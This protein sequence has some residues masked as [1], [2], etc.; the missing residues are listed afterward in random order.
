[1]QIC[2]LKFSKEFLPEEMKIK[3]G[4]FYQAQHDIN[5]LLIGKKIMTFYLGAN[6][7][8]KTLSANIWQLQASHRS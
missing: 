6:L 1:M 2:I 7:A 5:S 3:I 8:C 4:D